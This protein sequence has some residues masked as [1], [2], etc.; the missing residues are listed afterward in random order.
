MATVG[1]YTVDDRIE[2]FEE[3]LGLI[4]Q[5]HDALGVGMGGNRHF[6]SA[7]PPEVEGAGSG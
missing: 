1:R 2:A 6:Q 5:L 3:A 4:D 7:A